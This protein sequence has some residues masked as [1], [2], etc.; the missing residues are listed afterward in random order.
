MQIN[1]IK[2]R[3][4]QYPADCQQSTQQ[5]HFRLTREVYFIDNLLI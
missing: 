1:A 2:M 4:N 5:T 3:I